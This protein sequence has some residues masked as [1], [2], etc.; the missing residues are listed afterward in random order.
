MGFDP[1]EWSNGNG[2]VR[3]QPRIGDEALFYFRDLDEPEWVT[4]DQPW[5][6]PKTYRSKRKA[7]RV[8][9]REARDRAERTW[10]RVD[11]AR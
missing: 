2:K 8:A 7:I 10:V 11:T 1:V 6:T 5:G 4:K 3:Y 9:K